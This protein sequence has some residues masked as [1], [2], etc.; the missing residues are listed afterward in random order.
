MS[1]TTTAASPTPAAA[2][3][4]ADQPAPTTEQDS[5]PPPQPGATPQAAPATPFPEPTPTI[6]QFTPT[7][8]VLPP[9]YIEPESTPAL[10]ASIPITPGIVAPLAVLEPIPTPV[11]ALRLPEPTVTSIT[12]TDMAVEKSLVKVDSASKSDTK[13]AVSTTEPAPGTAAEAQGGRD[14]APEPESPLT[15]KF[16]EKEWTAL[17][18]FRSQLPDIFADA[19]PNNAS[20]RD[21]SI[22]IWGVDIDPKNPKADAR[23][24]VILV[25]FL[26]ANNLHVAQTREKFIGTLRWRE[27]F[28]MPAALEENF[29]QDIFKNLAHIYGLDKGGR[30]VIYNIYGG[31]Q[32]LKAVFGDVQRFIRWRVA[33]MEKSVAQLNFT[34]IDQMLQI[35]DYEGV[36]LTSRDANSKAAAS[37]ATNIFQNHYPELLYKKF[38]INVPTILN[39]IFWVFRP[40]ISANTLAKMSVVGTGHHAIKK[41]LSEYIDVTSLPKRY[42]GDAE[43]F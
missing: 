39:W 29:P 17:K 10:E 6:S 28:N 30:P 38:F 22:N 24:S 7:P 37:E 23:V 9:G 33:F 35:H 13:E 4:P 19:Y 1:E 43:A 15:K 36:S 11:E 40:L 14:D 12:N 31:N 21:T 8:E 27:S 2:P 20:A 5:P 32:D 42:G 18:E 25:K 26:R 41:A 16:T 34:D 3:A